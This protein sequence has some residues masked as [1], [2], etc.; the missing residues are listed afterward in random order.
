MYLAPLELPILGWADRAAKRRYNTTMSTTDAK[1]PKKPQGLTYAQAGVDIAAGDK[2]VD[3]IKSTLRRT[4]GP[5]VISQHGGFAGLFRLDYDE[6]L[7]KRNYKEPVLVA[8][9]DGVG[10]K[11]KL[12]AELK[13]YKTIGIDC[14]AMN[15]NDLI[16]Q[17]AEPLFFLDYLGLNKTDPELTAELIKGIGRGCEI[18]DCALLGGECAEMPDIYQKGDFDMAGFCV[19]VVELS[20]AVDPM[21]VQ[22]DDV[23]IGLSSDGIHSNGYTLVR[24][25]IKYAQLDLSSKPENLAASGERGTL[26]QAILKPTRIYVRPIVRLLNRYRVKRVISGMAHITGGGLPG[27]VNRILSPKIDAK[28]DTSTWTVP[29][30]FD[31][32]QEAGNVDRDEMYQVFN[33]G[34]GYVLVVRPSFATSVVN[35]LE[36]YGEK[37]TVIGEIVS[38]TGQVQLV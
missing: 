22:K 9:T 10:T 28:I 30:L 14:V 31:L 13:S 1:D 11:V 6:R 33:M 38:G 34:I 37:P 20:R 3:L 35:Q 18:S 15:V 19:G 26:G 17:G 36:R 12:A 32:L 21:R 25:I 7:F 23:I 2:V 5:R 8:C 16:V 29:P 27:N 24:E 4:H